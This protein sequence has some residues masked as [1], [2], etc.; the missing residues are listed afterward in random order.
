M[1]NISIRELMASARGFIDRGDVVAGESAVVDS[2]GE[3]VSDWGLGAGAGVTRSIAGSTSASGGATRHH[4]CTT[5]TQRSIC[6]RIA[7]TP[8][9]PLLLKA[10]STGKTSWAVSDRAASQKVA[11]VARDSRPRGSS[12]CWSHRRT[13]PPRAGT[14][15]AACCRRASPVVL[16]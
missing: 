5:R 2:E 6:T 16:T 15:G 1:C 13:P 8:A 14:P 11:R 12:V 10:E 7:P 3:S 9:L 4:V